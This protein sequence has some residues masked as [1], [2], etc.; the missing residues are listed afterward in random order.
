MGDKKPPGFLLILIIMLFLS[1]SL[2][3]GI[4]WW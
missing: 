3:S 1:F 2:L 4:P